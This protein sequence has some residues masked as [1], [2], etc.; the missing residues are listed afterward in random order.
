MR[1]AGL[2]GYKPYDST[3]MASGKGKTIEKTDSVVVMGKTERRIDYTKTYRYLKEQ[4]N[5]A[6]S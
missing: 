5:L 3:Y 4:W 6:T 1:E 2:R